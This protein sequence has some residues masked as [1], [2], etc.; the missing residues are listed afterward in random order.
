MEF[1]SRI[2]EMNEDSKGNK[3]YP[4]IE[5]TEGMILGGGDKYQPNPFELSL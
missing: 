5:L 1:S 2:I 3:G 4:N